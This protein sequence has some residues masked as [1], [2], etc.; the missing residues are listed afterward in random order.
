MHDLPESVSFVLYSVEYLINLED[1][2]AEE[3]R[4][5]FSRYT[6]VAC[7]I[8]GQVRTVRPSAYDA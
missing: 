8:G 4:K 5:S 1:A 3:L 7:K 2:R 6:K